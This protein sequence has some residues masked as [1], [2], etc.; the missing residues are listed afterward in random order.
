MLHLGQVVHPSMA[1]QGCLSLPLEPWEGISD[2]QFI[3][4]ENSPNDNQDGQRDP[5]R[6]GGVE[7]TW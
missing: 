3:F 1:G 4:K 7:G 6:V 2:V 5:I